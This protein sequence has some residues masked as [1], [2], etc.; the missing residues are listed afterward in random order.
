MAY[1]CGVYLVQKLPHNLDT[2]M[3]QRF[4]FDTE[5]YLFGRGRL[6]RISKEIWRFRNRPEVP[7]SMKILPLP[8]VLA[9]GCHLSLA[10][11][12]FSGILEGTGSCRA[13]ALGSAWR[14][15]EA[16]EFGVSAWVDGAHTSAVVIVCLTHR[17]GLKTSFC[18]ERR[19]LWEGPWSDLY[20]S[21]ILEVGVPLALTYLWNEAIFCGE[22]LAPAQKSS[23]S[24]WMMMQMLRMWMNQ[25]SELKS[26]GGEVEREAS[27]KS[28]MGLDGSQLNCLYILEKLMG[29]REGGEVGRW[30]ER[31]GLTSTHLQVILIRK[32]F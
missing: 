10:F 12:S 17:P 4:Q 29:G 13:S 24:E 5:R 6:A 31:L 11:A 7:L 28:R 18:W 27:R 8:L 1:D 30:R 2:F 3:I 25:K 32:T 15:G 9:M 22:A 14:L 23:I 21:L 19:C 16:E 26:E 20:F